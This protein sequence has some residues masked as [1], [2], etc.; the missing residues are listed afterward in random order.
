MIEGEAAYR[1]VFVRFAGVVAVLAAAAGLPGCA[2]IMPRVAVPLMAHQ[3]VIVEGFNDI[4]FRG[5][6]VTA[7]ATAMI[8]RQYRQIAQASGGDSRRRTTA[9]FL[10]ISGGGSDGAFS[11]GFL[12]GWTAS[13]TR[14]K[15]E[16]VTGVSTGALAAPFAFLGADYDAALRRIYTGISDKDVYTSNGPLGV[17]GES[18]LDASPLRKIVEA[19][20]TEEMLD[21]L[22]AEYEH[23][24][25]LLIQ[26]TDIERQIPYIWNVTRIA[27]QKS[28][29]R[30]KLIADVLMASAAVPGA[31]PPVRINVTVDGQ[32]I[33]ELH[34]DGGLAAQVFFAPPGLDMARFETKYFGKPRDQR[35]VLIRNGKL[36]TETKATEPTTLALAARAVST[37]IK[38][39]SLQDISKI[40][41]AFARPGSHFKVV[42]IPDT[43]SLVAGSLFDKDYMKALYKVGYEAGLRAGRAGR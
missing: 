35:L 11:A 4:R 32:A 22:A 18:L 12:N 20:L 29:D 10:A 16:I 1:R 30:R 43:F 40:Q 6:V 28:S 37:L 38:Y 13:G 26:T 21:R 7:G 5:D 2:T 19:E 41:G 34:V 36:S 27:S 23:G 14:P 24:R 33:E 31:F 9:D 3:A 42:S 17:L 39:Q 15:F 25:R 8:G